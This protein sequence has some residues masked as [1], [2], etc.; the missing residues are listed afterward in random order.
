MSERADLEREILAWMGEPA[1]RPDEA[2]FDALA[3]GLA[4]Q[5]SL[6]GVSTLWTGMLDAA[7]PP[8]WLWQ[9]WSL[10]QLLKRQGLGARL[11]TS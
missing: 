11:A 6:L 8:T 5:L 3:L 9:A 2:R 7:S 10:G 1:W 4:S